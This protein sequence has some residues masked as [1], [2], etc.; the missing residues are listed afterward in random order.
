MAPG[1]RRTAEGSPDAR[2]VSDATQRAVSEC[3]DH[4][5]DL[6][7]AASMLRTGHP[8]LAYHL[9]ALSLEEV[10][11]ST[12]L[13]ME[14]I[15][16]AEKSA[17]GG[18][19][20]RAQD[21]VGKLFWA[22]WGP[23][24]GREQITGEQIEQFRGLAEHVNQ[25]RQ[26]GLYYGGPDA[27]SPREAVSDDE[28]ENLIGLT[29]ARIGLAR[30]TKWKSPDE[31]TAGDLAWFLE[32]TE[33]PVRRRLILGA[34]SMEKLAEFE[35][36][37][38]WIRWLRE[39]FE[40]SEDAARELAEH[41]LARPKPSAAEAHEPKWMLK[42]RLES[43]S[44]SIR[45]QPLR[46]WNDISDWIKLHPVSG[47][48]REIIVHLTLPRAVSVQA[49]WWAAFGAANRLL[50]AL[51]I[52]SMGFFWWEL[53]RHD[54]RF[55]EELVDLATSNQLL[56]QRSPQL[57]VDWGNQVLTDRILNAV[58]LCFGSIPGSEDKERHLP[59]DHYLRGL[60]LLG[61]T[62]VFM[63]FETNSFEQF[64]RAFREA[65]RTFGEWNGEDP[66][67]ER[68]DQ[69][70]IELLGSEADRALYVDAGAAIEAG[71]P[72]QVKADLSHVA[73]MKLVT[74]SFLLRQFRKRLESDR[75]C[76]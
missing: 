44:H 11:R 48:H 10:G 62:D 21:H 65:S 15:A 52:G 12:L 3:L 45:P 60:A 25:T 4:A 37:G 40:A 49:L 67:V 18:Y 5:D 33:D 58:A 22:F 56:A 27:P 26:A 1:P 32:A 20:R 13:V 19:R 66:F 36:T 8:H 75:S 28:A 6:V 72:R 23:S 76:S 64:Y 69:L 51:N 17:G 61:K 63:Q 53:S 46:S 73:G 7:A 34:K 59:F 42:L 16:A 29:M 68:F 2:G 47:K 35:G 14:E 57:R 30:T 41:E 39:Q 71:N 9:A 55:Y 50:V 24:F 70:L 74:D 43:A 31:R 38:P 54:A